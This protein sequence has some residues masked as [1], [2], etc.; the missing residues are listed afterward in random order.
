MNSNLF[1]SLIALSCI[2]RSAGY[3]GRNRAELCVRRIQYTVTPFT[4][5]TSMLIIIFTSHANT[6]T[7]KQHTI[8]YKRPLPIPS[9]PDR[10]QKVLFRKLFRRVRT[11]SMYTAE[12]TNASLVCFQ[13]SGRRMVESASPLPSFRENGL[14]RGW[15][16]SH[17]NAKYS[18]NM[19]ARK[20]TV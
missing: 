19:N 18:N 6:P 4:R 12:R 8:A 20:R 3:V 15:W 14:Y 17:I 10:R 9:G 5:V 11:Y 13:F 16:G 7:Q 2:G 1:R